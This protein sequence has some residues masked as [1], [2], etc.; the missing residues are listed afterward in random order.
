MPLDE[1]KAWVLWP[2]YFDSDRTRAE[3]RRVSKAVAV[4]SPTLDMIVV[5]LKRIGV[6][7]KAEADRAYPGNWHEHKGR[8][9][10]E[11]KMTK[12]KLIAAVAEQLK[13]AQRS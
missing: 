8:V 1:E 11:K 13:K 9:L 12:T 10:V 3:G 2:E 7:H 6:E 5:A 4:S